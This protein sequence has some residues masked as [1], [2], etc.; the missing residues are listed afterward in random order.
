M[1]AVARVGDPTQGF[2]P[3]Q[4][5][6]GVN[7]VLINGI[8]IA[9]VGSSTNDS[10]PSSVEAGSSTVFAGR[11]PVAR[12]GDPIYDGDSIASGS[13]NVISG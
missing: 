3:A 9:I 1:P 5:T 13:P 2:T 10:P 4:I 12:V 8:P 7:S 6:S 11:Q